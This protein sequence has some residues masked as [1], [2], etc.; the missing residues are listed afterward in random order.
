M[1]KEHIHESSNLKF[2]RTKRKYCDTEV[3]TQYVLH[4]TSPVSHL[5]QIFHPTHVSLVPVLFKVVSYVIS[6]YFDIGD[7]KTTYEK[8][9]IALPLNVKKKRD[10]PPSSPSIAIAFARSFQSMVSYSSIT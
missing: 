1:I 4:V 5:T 7:C 9:G 6:F 10:D 2:K 8:A 3:R